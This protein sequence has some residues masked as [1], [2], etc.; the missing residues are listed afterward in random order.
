MINDY[1]YF[2]N[3]FVFKK[4]TFYTGTNLKKKSKPLIQTHFICSIQTL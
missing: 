2:N 3:T 4:K 1:I